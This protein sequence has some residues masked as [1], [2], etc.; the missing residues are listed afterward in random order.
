V[1]TSRHTLAQINSITAY[2]DPALAWA[3]ERWAI[4]ADTIT[5]TAA[6]LRQRLG[7]QRLIVIGCHGQAATG[8]AG[9]LTASDTT[10]VATAADLLAK[11]L[12]D[13]VLLLEAWWTSRY[14]GSRTGEHFTLATAA[15][16]EPAPTAS[17]PDYSHSRQMTSAPAASPPLSSPLY[18]TASTPPRRCAAPEPHTGRTRQPKCGCQAVTPL[19]STA[20][21]R[22]SRPGHGQ[23]YPP[24]ANP[25]SS[26]TAF[27]ASKV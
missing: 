23:A 7:P 22:V 24:T 2:F 17:S 5:D 14:V 26:P 6:E 9:A 10:V 11:R 3:P 4:A 8:L 13:S 25:E 15:L 12:D 21:Y 1:P 18:K 19:H 20:P 16:L 27:T